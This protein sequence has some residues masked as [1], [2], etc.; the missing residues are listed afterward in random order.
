MIQIVNMR[1]NKPT[2]PYDI[3]VDR[4]SPLGNPFWM[5]E[6]SQRDIV[7]D[8]YETWLQDKI[9]TKDQDVL[10]ALEYL[11]MIHARHGKLRLMCWCHPKR[12]HAESILNH[13]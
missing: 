4:S 9:D 1:C 10:D 11:K 2:Y 8:Q 3:K 12:C 5:N 13:L 7:C 6:E